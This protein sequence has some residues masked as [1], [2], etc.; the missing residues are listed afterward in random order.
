MKKLSISIFPL[1]IVL[2]LSI[3]LIAQ[4]YSRDRGTGIVYNEGSN[5]VQVFKSDEI[6]G[7]PFFKDDFVPG[8]VILEDDKTTEILLMDFDGFGQNIIVK[9]ANQYKV[10]NLPNTKGFVFLDD[11][12]EIKDYFAKGFNNPELGI[13][14]DNFVKVIYDGDVKLIGHFKVIF[15][16]ANFTRTV[17][18]MSTNKYDSELV[19]YIIRENGEYKETRLRAKNIIDDLGQ[20]KKE[21]KNFTKETKNNGRSDEEAAKILIQYETLLQNS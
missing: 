9:R 8:R 20:F 12:E 5:I 10:L 7:T 18:S 13:K 16:Q 15:E 21:L 4:P 17:N 3:S 11:N 19:Y 6:S 14:P 1:L 2:F